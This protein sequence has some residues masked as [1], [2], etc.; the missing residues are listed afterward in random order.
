MNIDKQIILALIIILI[1]NIIFKII[2]INRK[3]KIISKNEVGLNL[4]EKFPEVDYID[5]ERERGTIN[6]SLFIN[7]NIFIV[8]DSNCQ[9]CSKVLEAME[10]IDNNYFEN[11]KFLFV[12]TPENYNK[13][14][15]HKFMH[16]SIFLHADS[17]THQLKINAF[18]FYYHVNTSGEI[19]D[20]GFLSTYTII[21]FLK[22][23][24][25]YPHE[26]NSSRE[27]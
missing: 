21:D 10:V 2:I 5:L 13:A 20:K 18:P 6:K 11:V 16:S 1:L 23:N 27:V 8:M 17:L 22:E 3:R 26:K 12:D 19:I 15:Q 25:I 24:K 4:G 14:S 7:S 9:E